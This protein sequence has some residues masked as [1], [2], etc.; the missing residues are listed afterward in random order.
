MAQIGRKGGKMSR[1]Q[2]AMLASKIKADISE[3]L[4]DDELSDYRQLYQDSSVE[5]LQHHRDAKSR[6]LSYM[7]KH[8]G[9]GRFGSVNVSKSTKIPSRRMRDDPSFA[10]DG[11]PS[12]VELKALQ[13]YRRYYDKASDTM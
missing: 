7:L 13:L 4:S 1:Y 5:V 2:R 10:V 9:P 6:N 3:K 8:N 11:S 12:K